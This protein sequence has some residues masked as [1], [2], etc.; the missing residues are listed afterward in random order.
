MAS[1]SL[2]TPYNDQDCGCDAPWQWEAGVVSVK[3]NLEKVLKELPEDRLR[4]VLDFAEFLNWQ[5]DTN[6]WRQFGKAQFARAYGPDEP[7]YTL[8]DLKAEPGP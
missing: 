6:A 1:G 7:E 3:E 4:S 5:D 8:S 2:L